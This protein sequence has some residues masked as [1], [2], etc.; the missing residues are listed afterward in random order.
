MKWRC[1]LLR[2]HGVDGGWI[3]MSMEECW[4]DTDRR[5]TKYLKK[6]LSQSHFIRHKSHMEWRGVEH[7]ALRRLTAWHA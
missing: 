5:A 1:Q 7:V 4:N 2:S 3:N 6:N